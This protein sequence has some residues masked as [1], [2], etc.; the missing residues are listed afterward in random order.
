MVQLSWNSSLYTGKSLRSLLLMSC[1]REQVTDNDWTCA[2][3]V[4]F[5]LKF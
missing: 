2:L 4:G 3:R 5:S 1:L